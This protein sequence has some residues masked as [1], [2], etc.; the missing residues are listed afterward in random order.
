MQNRPLLLSGLFCIWGATMFASGFPATTTDNRY[1][2]IAKT[3]SARCEAGGKAAGM[4][5]DCG[6]IVGRKTER[7]LC[8]V[9][10]NRQGTMK[11]V[12][13]D[14]NISLVWRPNRKVDF[15]QE[16]AHPIA[17][18][19]PDAEGETDFVVDHWTFF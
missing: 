13:P 15:V 9:E 5:T 7:Y 2:R 10:E 8:N 11:M 12:M 4:R 14:P 1:A 17:A 3:S 18:M 19:N 6:V 16:A